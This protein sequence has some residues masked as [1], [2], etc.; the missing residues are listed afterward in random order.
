MDLHHF[1]V[2]VLFATQHQVRHL[3]GVLWF[4]GLTGRVVS[5]FNQS[6]N[7]IK[8]VSCSVAEN[9]PRLATSTDQH[10]IRGSTYESRAEH[11]KEI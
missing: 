5:F 1:S 8:A 10:G 7:Q 6:I 9:A 4:M 3:R 11:V 2:L